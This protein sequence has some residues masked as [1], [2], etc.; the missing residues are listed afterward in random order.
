MGGMDKEEGIR[1]SRCIKTMVNK[2]EV[3]EE[4]EEQRTRTKLGLCTYMYR[5]YSILGCVKKGNRNDD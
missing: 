4:C 5:L 3:V 1:Q 2:K